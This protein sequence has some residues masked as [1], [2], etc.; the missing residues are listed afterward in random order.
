MLVLGLQGVQVY[1]DKEWKRKGERTGTKEWQEW[2]DKGA[3][4]YFTQRGAEGGS[5]GGAHAHFISFTK[6]QGK[7][8]LYRLEL[9]VTEGIYNSDSIF[10]RSTNITSKRGCDY[11]GEEH[12]WCDSGQG[13][14]VWWLHNIHSETQTMRKTTDEML[15]NHAL[16]HFKK[17]GIFPVCCNL[18]IRPGNFIYTIHTLGN[19]VWTVTC[20]ALVVQVK[21]VDT[22]KMSFMFLKYSNPIH[23]WS[24]SLLNFFVF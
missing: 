13:N 24:P 3:Q 12:K 11:S 21:S 9:T 6:I 20:S 16:A 19:W 7:R 23:H 17:V 2:S 5:V 8:K 15:H 22:A 4:H 18:G 10:I 1:C 14:N